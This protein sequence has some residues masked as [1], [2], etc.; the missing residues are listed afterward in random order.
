MTDSVSELDKIKK[1]KKLSNKKYYEKRKLEAEMEIQETKKENKNNNIECQAEESGILDTILEYT[2]IITSG[3]V[4]SMGQVVMTLAVPV[5]LTWIF[6][7]T[8][9]MITNNPTVT[10]NIS[11]LRPTSSDQQSTQVDQQLNRPITSLN[12]LSIM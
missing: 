6:P 9:P 3:I 5:I 12:S 4:Q 2:K 8:P 10:Q 1:Q 11:T 7:R